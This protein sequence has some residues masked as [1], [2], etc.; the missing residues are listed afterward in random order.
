MKLNISHKF[1]KV[2]EEDKI[3]V[4]TD[5][6]IMSPEI[7]HTVEIKTYPIEVEEITIGIIDQIIEVE[8]KTTIDMMIGKTTRH[9]ARQENYRQNDRCDNY[10]QDH[11]RDNY[12]TKYR[13]NYERDNHRELRYRTRS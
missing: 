7:G 13:P 5:K 11:G 4:K 1:T 6:K 2:E 12:R 3:D 10:R 8:S 9:D